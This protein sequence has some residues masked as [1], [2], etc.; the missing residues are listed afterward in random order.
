VSDIDAF[1]DALAKLAQTKPV[2]FSGI[3]S[4]A[5]GR[6]ASQ[7]HLGLAPNMNDVIERVPAGVVLAATS[8]DTL[9]ACKA[10]LWQERSS[11]RRLA[12][13]TGTGGIGAELA[14]LAVLRG[15]ELPKLSS[16]LQTRL[17]VHLPPF[18]AAGN[19]VDVTPIWWEYP[20]VYPA[21]ILAL[22]ESDEVDLLLVSITDIPTTDP[23]LAEAISA[24][25]TRMTKPICVFWGSR[26]TDL[27]PMQ[28]LERA[29]IPCYRTT[30]AAI[31]AAAAL[32]Q[33]QS[34][35]I[36]ELRRSS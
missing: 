2:V 15:L 27:G 35:Q 11:G 36:S 21:L 4:T 26:N 25:A 3:G 12:I 5:A 32:A 33:G 17:R 1:V 9:D 24:V 6:R 7:A 20:K 23:D 10:L 30:A 22:D 8:R 18:A 29:G 19:P 28:R 16:E 31:N 14:D 13:V 34:I